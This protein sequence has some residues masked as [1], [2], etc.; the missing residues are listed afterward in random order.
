MK[1][2]KDIQEAPEAIQNKVD[3][4]E[5]KME[6]QEQREDKLGDPPVRSSVHFQKPKIKG[7]VSTTLPS[8]SSLSSGITLGYYLSSPWISGVTLS[9]TGQLTSRATRGNDSQEEIS[10]DA[11]IVPKK[12]DESPIIGDGED[13]FL[14]LFGD[15]KKRIAHSSYTEKT[16]KY[17]SSILEEVGKFTSSSLGDV[18]IAEVNVKG[19]FIKLVN[20][21]LDKEMAIGDHILQQNVNG[22]T[23]SLYQFLP[24]I[25]MQANST[26]TVWAAASEAKHQP[27][28]DFL[29]KEQDKFRASPDCITIL[30]KPN[31]QAIAW[32]TPIHWKQAWEKLETDIEFDRC[33]VVSPTF[34]RHKFQWTASTTTITKEKEDQP[35]NHISNY[36]VEQ[37]QVFLKREKKIP[38]TV[39]P[40]RSPW[41][42]NPYVSAHPYCP[43]IEPHNTCITGDSLGRQPRSRSTRPNRAPGTKKKKTSESQKQ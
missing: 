43:L 20:S 24:N 33:S 9:T 19:L 32:Y 12:Q 28:S 11:F 31:G 27:P 34:R 38:P 30:C 21:S 10:F 26:V 5:D 25:V 14:S 6:K 37:T 17:F 2:T 22:Q 1:D 18:K 39:F 7:S 35:K 16:F 15:S 23:I 41:C 8:S 13:Y 3:K 29:W 36:Q 4:Q 40:N 42:Q